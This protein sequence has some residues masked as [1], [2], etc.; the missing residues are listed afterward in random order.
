MHKT[1]R[2][3]VYIRQY[4]LRHDG[5][6]KAQ[7]MWLGFFCGKLVSKPPFEH[8]APPPFLHADLHQF[9]AFIVEHV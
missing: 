3:E 2:S 7:P 1:W 6:E 9:P 4:T 8:K 5:T